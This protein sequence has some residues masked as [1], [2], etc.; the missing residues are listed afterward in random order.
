MISNDI[1]DASP[2]TSIVSASVNVDRLAKVPLPLEACMD[3]DSDGAV[4]G[5]SMRVVRADLREKMPL[6]PEAFE[7]DKA[8][9]WVLRC[10]KEG[11]YTDINSIHD[12]S[13][14]NASADATDEADVYMDIDEIR[15]RKTERRERKRIAETGCESTSVCLH[16]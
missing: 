15:K 13:D 4:G 2:C 8:S 10:E 12:E 1:Y 11:D 7:T 6:P 5:A 9:V 14:E 16:V 3:D